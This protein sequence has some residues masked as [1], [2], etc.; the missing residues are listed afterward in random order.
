MPT[1]CYTDN[2]HKEAVP[3]KLF[4]FC[5]IEHYREYANT[6]NRR[7]HEVKQTHMSLPEAIARCRAKAQELRQQK[8]KPYW[9][10]D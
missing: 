2:C 7:V 10:S 6:Q 4:P 3:G 5:S 9:Q 8:V 1:E